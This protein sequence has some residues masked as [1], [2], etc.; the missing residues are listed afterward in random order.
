MIGPSQRAIPNDTQHSQQTHINTPHRIRTRNPSKPATADTR[1]RL[2]G[3][4][5]TYTSTERYT[6]SVKLSEFTV[7]SHTWRKNWVNCTVLTGNSAGL[8][9]VFS[10][11]L[12][13][14]QLRSSLR[15]SHSFLSLPADITMASSQGTSVSNNSFGRWASHDIF[16]FKYHFLLHILRFLF[17]FSD[18]IMTGVASKQQTTA[19]FLSTI[20]TRTR[21]HT[22][23]TKKTDK[24]DGKPVLCQRTFSSVFRAVFCFLHS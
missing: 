7:W 20:V 12:S 6:L 4:C 21:R 22:E 18:N 24:P 3:H 1:I 14:R 10:S 15:E 23:L 2:R 11:R 8:R 19:L 16:P 13:H 9:N 17:F 5:V